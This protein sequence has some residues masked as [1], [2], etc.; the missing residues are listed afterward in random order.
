[1]WG[2]D[3]PPVAGREGYANALQLCQHQ[4][5]DRPAAHQAAI[6]GGVASTVFARR[7]TQ[8]C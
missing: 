2:S 4:F 1:M 8:G 6:F 5:A 7:P 3:F